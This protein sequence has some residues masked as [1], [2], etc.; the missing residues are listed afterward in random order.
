M[1]TWLVQEVNTVISIAFV[2]SFGLGASYLIIHFAQKED[3]RL[4]S[5]SVFTEDAPHGPNSPDPQ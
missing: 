2:A 3:Y 4:V 1:R 5:T